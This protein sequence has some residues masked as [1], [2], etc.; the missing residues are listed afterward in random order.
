MRYDHEKRHILL[1]TLGRRELM[2]KGI[3]PHQRSSRLNKG[4]NLFNIKHR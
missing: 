1:L 4:L 2:S 3:G